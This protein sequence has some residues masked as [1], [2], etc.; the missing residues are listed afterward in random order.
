MGQKWAREADP[1][2]LIKK[3]AGRPLIESAFNL[4]A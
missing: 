2:A 3:G 1:R 4:I